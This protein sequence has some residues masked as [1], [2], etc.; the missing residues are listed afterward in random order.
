MAKALPKMTVPGLKKLKAEK[1]KIVAL[2]CYDFTT[3]QL[4]NEAGVDLILVGDSLGM[5]K[6]GYST[7]LPV[8]VEDMLYHT[9]IVAKGNSRAVLVTDMPYLS[10]Q[11]SPEQAVENCGRM[12][13]AGA[14]AVKV[15]GGME[16]LP[17]IEALKAAKIPVMGHLGM[18]PQSVHTFGGFK[19]Q[20]REA[21]AAGKLEADAL[22]LERAGVF[23]IVLECIPAVVAKQVSQS[24]GIPTIG[25]GAGAGC[26]GQIL[27]I[28]DLIGL[29]APETSPRFVK[30]YA[31]VR[32]TVQ[33]AAARYSREVR[34]GKFPDRK[35]AYS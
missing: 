28:D 15:E 12:L 8:T 9:L 19:V 11:I 3:A 7:T 27:V 18:T 32:Q 17:M 25:I 33:D 20:A 29:T 4:L 2:T 1:R 24:L 23:A 13:K 16:I 21:E 26:D 30:R 5:V 31:N 35:H 6:L 14:Q 10:Y 34:N 22:A